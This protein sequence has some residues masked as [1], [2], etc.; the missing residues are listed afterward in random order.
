M[1][2]PAPAAATPALA[3]ASAPALAP[4]LPG[5]ALRRE[6]HSPFSPLDKK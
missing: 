4:G 1:D 2:P 3:L 5:T 6:T